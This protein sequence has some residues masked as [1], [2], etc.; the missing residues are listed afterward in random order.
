MA[1]ASERQELNA[2][3]MQLNTTSAQ[4]KA[5]ATEI[6]AAELDSV[7]GGKMPRREITREEWER[8]AATNGFDR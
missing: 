3:N 8:L 7:V 5:G 4:G 2:T 1:S 6:S